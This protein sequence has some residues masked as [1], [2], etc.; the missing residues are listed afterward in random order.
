MGWD[1]VKLE[2]KVSASAVLLLATLAS[3]L[4]LTEHV[5]KMTMRGNAPVPHTVSVSQGAPA[6]TIARA[7]PIERLMAPHGAGVLIMPVSGLSTRAL[8][9]TWGQARSEGRQHQGIDIMAPMGT[10]V[11]AAADGRI[12]KFFDSERG[13]VT[14]YQFDAAEHWVYYYAHLSRRAPA[15]AEGDPVVQGQVIGF[16]GETG[17]ATTPHLHFEL[18]RLGPDRKW[19]VADA[20]NPYPYLVRSEAPQ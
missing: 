16:V 9:D 15:L 17:N 19:W 6:T 2:H 8:V 18:Q 10:P 7:T 4:F 1:G 3:L 5:R 12:V 14:I 11:I 13:G 20:V